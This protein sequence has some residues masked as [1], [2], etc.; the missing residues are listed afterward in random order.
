MPIDTFAAAQEPPAPRVDP[1]RHTRQ[2]IEFIRFHQK[3]PMEKFTAHVRMTA[4]SPGS[5]QVWGS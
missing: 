2:D 1:V 5:W 4:F 3:R